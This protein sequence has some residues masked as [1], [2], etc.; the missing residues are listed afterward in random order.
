M[1]RLQRCRSMQILQI[2]KNAVKRIYFLAKFRFD[3]AENEPAKIC[4]ICKK[5]AN[6]PNFADPNPGES[7]VM[8]CCRTAN[9]DGVC[10]CSPARG[11]SSAAPLASCSSGARQPSNATIRKHAHPRARRLGC[12]KGCGLNLNFELI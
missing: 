8:L 3:T 5:N 9:W 6:F 12:K 11:I 1:F 2:L 7:V 10:P 4:K